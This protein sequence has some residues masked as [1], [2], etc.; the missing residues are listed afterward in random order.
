MCW[1]WPYALILPH[2]GIPHNGVWVDA[3]VLAWRSLRIQT[4]N[5][6]NSTRVIGEEGP[7]QDIKASWS[8]AMFRKGDFVPSAV[9]KPSLPQSGKNL[10]WKRHS[11]NGEGG[12]LVWLPWIH[13][14]LTFWSPVLPQPATLF[15]Q[16]P[17]RTPLHRGSVT[18]SWD[19]PIPA[20]C[21]DGNPSSSAALQAPHGSPS[22]PYPK[23]GCAWVGGGRG[24]GKTR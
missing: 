6:H 9:V 17:G 7:V 14:F 22:L 15:L 5:F 11:E 18:V 20:P 23:L 12:L 13:W 8:P 19:F 2:L 24:E 16:F 3:E 4:S 10:K 1:P 21:I